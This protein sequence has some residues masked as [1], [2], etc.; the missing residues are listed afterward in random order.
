M[1]TKTVN[2]SF[3]PVVE[4]KLIRDGPTTTIPAVIDTG[5]SGDL[6]LSREQID[7]MDL[8]FSWVDRF[9]LVG[10]SDLFRTALSPKQR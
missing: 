2:D 9:E 4:I 3:E 1:I 6:C 7:A 10:S 5:F 8:E